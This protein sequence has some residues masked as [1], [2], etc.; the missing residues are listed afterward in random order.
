MPSYKNTKRNTW[1]C[2]FYFTDWQGNRKKKKKEGF[3]TKHAAQEWERN[4]LEQYTD[5]PN[6]SFETL[7]NAYKR[8]HQDNTLATTHYAKTHI[9]D[10]HILPYFVG[11][12]VNKIT[13]QHISDWKRK[14]LAMKF[15]P[16][17]A[18]QIYLLL[19]SI[20]AFA[21]DHYNLPANPCPCRE[22]FGKPNKKMNY[23]TI[24]EFLQFSMTLTEPHHIVAFYLL[25][26]TGMR[27]GEL[28]ALTWDDINF[29]ANSIS[30]DKS[31][32][33]L[34]KQDIITT[35][36]TAASQ[37][38]VIM[39][40][41]LTAMLK[42]YQHLRKKDSS[43]IFPFT[44]NMLSFALK[45]GIRQAQVKKIRIHDLRHSH[46]SL[47]INA[48]FNPIDVADR[49]G[50]ADSHIT[51]SIYSHFYDSKRIS[52]AEKLNTIH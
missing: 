2:A 34:H 1:Y 47:L 17:Y 32:T 16:S 31:Y 11:K 23:W 21:V 4:F 26:W 19:K 36:K 25:F 29:A 38:I 35:G 3:K 10:K 33:R 44:K 9:I 27:I 43:R 37:R 39:P 40:Q 18:K 51:L 8:H 46:A 48:G 49:L 50:H 6:I 22:C 12:T 52:L 14:L 7:I 45:K 30:I 24:D 28:L 13:K 20:F 41:F 15:Q 5:S 42:E